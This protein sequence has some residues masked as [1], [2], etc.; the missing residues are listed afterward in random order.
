MKLQEIGDA[1]VVPVIEE[2][3]SGSIQV[4][5]WPTVVELKDFVTEGRSGASG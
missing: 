5:Q 1:V 3:L 2:G 4:D